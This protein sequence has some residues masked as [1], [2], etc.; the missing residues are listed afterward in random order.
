MAQD[1]IDLL[2]VMVV[3][4]IVFALS[5]L[6]TV[7]LLIAFRSY[8]AS[9]PVIGSL[10]TLDIGNLTPLLLATRLFVVLGAVF[11]MGSGLTLIL[12]SATID[13][14]MLIIAKA[15]SLLITAI[16]G[17]LAG[18]WGYVRLAQGSELALPGINRLAIALIV[19]FVLSSMLRTATIRNWGAM[20]FVAAAAMIVLAPVV[21]V[22]L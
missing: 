8:A 7:Y 14:A 17:V 15:M 21:L 9:V 18:L 19:F 20:R 3:T 22:S 11:L 2:K 6:A 5:T 4:L 10:P 12:S 13:M 16:F 1:T